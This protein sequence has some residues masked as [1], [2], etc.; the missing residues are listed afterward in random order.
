MSWGTGI[1]HLAIYAQIE[2]AAN[3]QSSAGGVADSS[4][5]STSLPTNKPKEIAVNRNFLGFRTT[6][7][8][9]S[10]RYKNRPITE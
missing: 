4:R 3:P 8:S 5:R 2:N 1:V 10:D 9:P 7:N 6:E